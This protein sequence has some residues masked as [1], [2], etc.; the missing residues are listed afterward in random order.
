MELSDAEVFQVIAEVD[1]AT[2]KMESDVYHRG[3]IDKK[4]F[5]D[6]EGGYIEKAYDNK[7]VREYIFEQ[8]KEDPETYVHF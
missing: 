7:E 8:Q 2:G 6:W 3:V 5:A 4:M 1:A